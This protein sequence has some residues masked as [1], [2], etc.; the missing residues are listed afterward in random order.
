MTNS[1]TIIGASAAG[2]T[3]AKTIRQL[4]SAADITVFSG[5]DLPITNKCFWADYALDLKQDY[6]ITIANTDI[7]QQLNIKFIKSY[8]NRLDPVNNLLFCP[9]GSS[10]SYKKLIIAC[11]LQINKLDIKDCYNLGTFSD[12]QLLLQDLKSKNIKKAVIIGAGLTGIEVADFAKKYVKEVVL[13]DRATYP[14]NNIIS[15]RAGEF[16]IDKLNYHGINFMGECNSTPDSEIYINATG[17]RP[18]DWLKV[19]DNQNGLL[20]VNSMMQCSEANIWAAG[21][22]IM[23]NDRRTGQ[24]VASTLWP[25]AIRQGMLAAKSTVGVSI[26]SYEGVLPLCSSSFVGVRFVAVPKTG[27]ES[28]IQIDQSNDDFTELAF[29]D[30]KLESYTLIGKCAQ[31]A[32]LKRTLLTS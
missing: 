30:D 1:Y 20:R 29:I 11:G 13:I 25:D 26:N 16:I 23:V 10:Y 18:Q 19:L 3:A 5:E 27:R 32:S 21:D 24:M 17:A 14:L 7:F 12:L 31:A 4:D 9:D 2:L 6:E 22:C 15:H 28:S 8:I